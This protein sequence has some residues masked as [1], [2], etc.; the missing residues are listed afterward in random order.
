MHRR[1]GLLP[2]QPDAGDDVAPLVGA[3]D[4]QR[5]AVPLVQLH[6]VVGLQQHV[7]ELGVGD[8]VTFEPAPDRVAVEHHVHREVLADVAEELDRRQLRRSRTG[9]SRRRRRWASRRTPRSARAGPGCGRPIPRRCRRC[10]AC[11]RRCRAGSPI[12]PVAPPAS[13]IGRCPAC[14]KRRSVSSG[15]RWPACRLGAVGI[16]ARVDGRGSGGQQFGQRVAVGRL[17]DQS[18]P[19]QLVEDRRTHTADL[20]Y[21][22]VFSR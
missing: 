17:C 18:A 8:A 16:E 7:A 21:R 3:A 2:D 11:V 9:C 13:T 15:T 14:W 22:P 1:T 10:S 4:L 6:V 12:I 20:A 5:A 19:V